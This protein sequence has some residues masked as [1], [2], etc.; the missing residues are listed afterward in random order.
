MTL[1]SEPCPRTQAFKT[2]PSEFWLLRKM[3]GWGK[4]V[5]GLLPQEELRHRLWPKQLQKEKE[6]S[7]HT[8]A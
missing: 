3:V 2:R 7:G 4:L 6:D 8:P 1:A 5:S